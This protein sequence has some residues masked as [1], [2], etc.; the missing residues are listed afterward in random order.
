MEGPSNATIELGTAASAP[1]TADVASRLARATAGTRTIFS[2]VLSPALLP[3]L[4][5]Q[6]KRIPILNEIFTFKS[7]VMWS[8]PSRSLFNAVFDTGCRGAFGP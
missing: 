4:F 6:P 3:Q 2:K 8:R 5:D 7:L 1:A